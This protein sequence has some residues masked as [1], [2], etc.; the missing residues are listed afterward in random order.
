[1]RLHLRKYAYFYIISKTCV[2]RGSWINQ[3]GLSPVI[4]MRGLK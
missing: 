2:S 1:M 3:T 4:I